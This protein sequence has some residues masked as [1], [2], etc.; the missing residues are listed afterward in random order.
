MPKS[1]RPL[2]ASAAHDVPSCRW[3]VEEQPCILESVQLDERN[4]HRAQLVAHMVGRWSGLQLAAAMEV[5]RRNSELLF[6]RR[7]HAHQL[8]SADGM[9]AMSGAA[10]AYRTGTLLT[11]AASYARWVACISSI[12]IRMGARTQLEGLQRLNG[13][14]RVQR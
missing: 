3:Y 5:W 1:L 7:V 6:A 10:A 14:A 11:L 12:A 13:E 8:L 2:C 4:A 9:N